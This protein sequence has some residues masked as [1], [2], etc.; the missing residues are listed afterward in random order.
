MAPQSGVLID[1]RK[2]KEEKKGGKGKKKVKRKGKR[3][4]CIFWWLCGRNS[5][6]NKQ[7][8]MLSD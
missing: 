3:L 8:G 1:T 6:G 5:N 4:I 2:G 7:N